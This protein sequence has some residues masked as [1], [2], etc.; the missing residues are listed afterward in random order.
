MSLA[1]SI[2]RGV[3]W[4]HAGRIVEYGLMY[5]FSVLVARGLGAE[6]N[7]VYVTFYTLAQF[8][9]LISGLGFETALTRWS[10]QHFRMEDMPRLRYVLRRLFG[11]RLAGFLAAASLFYFFR[12]EILRFLALSPTAVEYFLLLIL[13]AGL[14]CLV[15]L[16]MAIFVSRFNI[17]IV[18]LIS[19]SARALEVIATVYSL[20]HGYGLEAILLVII[21]G[22]AYSLAASLIF[23]RRSYWGQ[24]EREDPRPVITLGAT[25]WVNMIMSF[26]LEKQGDIFLLNNLLGDRREVSYYDVA[27]ALMQVVVYGF[28]I[29]FS[30]ISL[31]AFSRVASSNPDSLGQLW[32]FSVKVIALLVLPP[33]IFLV[34]HAKVIIPAIYSSQYAG[35]IGLFQ[36][37]VLFQIA[38]R[39]FGSGT[40]ADVLLAINKPRVLVVFGVLAGGLNILLDILLIPRYRAYG[41]VIATGIAN[42]TV[43]MMSALYIVRRFSVFV[44]VGFWLKIVA[45]SAV[46]ALVGRYLLYPETVVGVVF[47]ALI[48]VAIWILLMYV[49]KLFSRDDIDYIKKFN[50]QLSEWA[51]RFAV[52]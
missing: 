48:Y 49:F 25:F 47:C 42:T 45:I 22:A 24:A 33:L 2:V 29:G 5:V 1:K 7:G 35:S 40:N 30:G 19:V 50:F 34:A 32:K 44:S 41:A 31:A 36:F 38:A 3:I 21:G 10:A 46:S 43:V 26:V 16:F 8:L 37:L 39:L 12:L 6:Q 23:G 18:T 4:N 15:P 9:L 27:F 11:W 52:T 17:R 13:Y 28:T 14:R 20:S 51:S